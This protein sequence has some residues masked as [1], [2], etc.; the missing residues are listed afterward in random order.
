MSNLRRVSI[1][2]RLFL[3]L[4][5][6][7]GLALQMQIGVPVARA[8]TF[9]VTNLDDSGLGSLR[10]AITSANTAGG[11]DTIIFSPALTLP[12]TIILAS[13][14][15]AVTDNLNIDGPGSN[16]LTIN[17]N[18]AHRIFTVNAGNTLSIDD[19]TLTNGN[20]TGGGAVLNNSN[21]T[22]NASRVVFQS[23]IARGVNG[24]DGFLSGGIIAGGGGGGAGM[25]GAIFND[26][27]TLNINASTFVGNRAFGGVG[28]N[29]RGGGG[30]GSGVGGAIFS[31]RGNLTINGST[32]E[33]NRAIGGNGGNGNIT[34][35]SNS[36]GGAGG[37]TPGG[38]GGTNSVAGGNS[39]YG[40]GGGNGGAGPG[41]SQFGGGGGSSNIAGAANS[42]LGGNGGGSGSGA[43]GGLGLGGALVMFGNFQASGIANLYN[44]TFSGNQAVGANGGTGIANGLA[45]A[46]QGGALAVLFGATINAANTTITLNQALGGTSPSQLAGLG[47]GVFVNGTTPNATFR[48]KNS[49]VAGNTNS[50]N[51]PA[52]GL[53]IRNLSASA[54]S[55]GYVLLGNQ[56]GAILNGDSSGFQSGDPGLEPLAFYG[57]PVKTHALKSTSQAL[58]TGNPGGCTDYSTP[59]PQLLTTDARGT[60]FVRAD[61]TCDKG[62]YERQPNRGPTVNGP[63]SQNGVE[64]VPT[65][66]SA[67]NGNRLTIND[68]DAGDFPV[69][70]I[71]STSSGNTLTLGGTAGLTFGP[72][73]GINDTSMTFTGT[74]TAINA[75]LNGLT[76]VTPAN[77]SGNTGFGFTLSD[78]GNTGSSGNSSG[79]RAI[80]VT[81][82]ATNDAPVVNAP[83]A[84]QFINQNTSR[85]FN[86][87]NQISLTDVDAGSGQISTTLTAATGRI[88]LS[89]TANLIFLTGDGTND[90][91]MTFLGTLDD[92]NAALNNLVYTPPANFT[93]NTSFAL[94]VDDQGNTGGAALNAT[95]TVNI[96]VVNV[97]DPPVNTVPG[98]QTI[99]EGATLAFTGATQIS[100]SDPDAGAGD[101][102][103]VSLV[104][105]STVSPP[106]GGLTLST[107]GLNFSVGD[108]TNDSTMTFIG[109]KTD[110]NAA[111]ATLTYTPASFFSGV[112]TLTVTTDD[113]GNSGPGGILTDTDSVAIT[114]LSAVIVRS[115]TDNGT[116]STFGSLS[117]A[118]AAAN[119]PARP[120]NDRIIT[121]SPGI[122]TVTVTGG[123][124]L[125]LGSGVSLA[126]GSCV[127]PVTLDGNGTNVVGLTLNGNNTVSGLRIVDF[128]DKLLVANA[129]NGANTLDCVRADKTASQ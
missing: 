11:V 125:A 82:A 50:G 33:D 113:Q 38:A 29:G 26:T 74:L 79:G 55:E 75:A 91:A 19:M 108:G 42:Q 21:A 65:V 32:F 41:G 59:V 70:V 104:L 62:A 126:G 49:I 44:S 27:G 43:N 23:N 116:G 87:A 35:A 24:N 52:D 25:G 102:I 119:N 54:V 57:G 45:S 109:T 76:L 111:L 28:G 46:G 128:D 103:Q 69:R 81:I 9:I 124:G 8:E 67:A 18:N 106:P 5:L 101:D 95:K 17:G 34:G 78:L 4:A 37:T 53:D 16:L 123:T 63:G 117:G 61:A 30:G 3:S 15:P 110:V 64:D 120:A 68:I 31:L 107:T 48:F 97:N 127:A 99:N 80:N 2:N 93:G 73:D 112:V 1:F 51:N 14:L 118:I 12:G 20:S 71:L 98:V 10:T 122:T 56:T 13:P 129:T 84:T 22:F 105:S 100:I 115:G 7:G 83:A 114:V 86:G 39:I 92:V 36:N 96:T 85:T 6:L 47:G 90:T 94:T 66:F 89:G 121:F 72:G 88:S 40:G 60:G 58:N 77:F